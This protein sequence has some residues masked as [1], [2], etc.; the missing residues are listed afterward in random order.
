MANL[1]KKTKDIKDRILATKN[2]RIEL[3]EL[4]PKTKFSI[5]SSCFA[6]GDNINVSWVDGPTVEEVNKI[7]SKY[8]EGHYDGM[9]DIYEY[10]TDRSFNDEYGGVKYVFSNR[11]YTSKFIKLATKKAGMNE[12]YTK[13]Y[14]DESKTY[15]C[16]SR[17]RE[18][19]KISEYELEEVK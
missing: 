11:R 14:L 12:E 8:E 16:D 6:G 15:H 19:M 7:I 4:F 3:K 2:I 17:L 10:N 13:D 18:I 1:I 9:N 5:K